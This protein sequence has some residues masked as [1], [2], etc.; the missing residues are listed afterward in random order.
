MNL[1]RYTIAKRTSVWVLIALILLG[2]YISYLNWVD[3]RT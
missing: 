3:L 1:A 2:G